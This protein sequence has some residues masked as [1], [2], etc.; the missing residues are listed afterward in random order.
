MALKTGERLPLPL[1]FVDKQETLFLNENEIQG[2]TTQYIQNQ[3][4]VL[5]CSIN[6]SGT[7]QTLA[8]EDII[9]TGINISC[10]ANVPAGVQIISVYVKGIL[11][12]RYGGTAL[13][14][15]FE[16]IPL[17]NIILKENEDVSIV[18]ADLGGNV[19]LFVLF[20]GYKA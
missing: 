8:T 1:D 3:L 17:P 13:I 18:L 7:A 9:L 4:K 11:I 16:N 19:Q 14:S 10:L 6:A 2:R 20:Y 5:E 12:Y 15:Y